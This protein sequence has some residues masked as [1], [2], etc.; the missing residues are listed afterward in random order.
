MPQIRPTKEENFLDIAREISKRSTCLRRRYGAV[1]VSKDGRIVSTGYNGAPRTRKNCCDLGVCS[2]VKLNIKPGSNYELCRAVHAEANAILNGNAA[3]IIGSTL[4]LAG[5]DSETNK[6]T[7]YIYPCSM[8]QRL[9]LNAQIEK[10]V[11]EDPD[12]MIITIS[13]KD[14]E[15]DA[16]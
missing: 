7:K 16:I 8:C 2:R 1:I 3:D 10:I 15:D 11:M 6:P 12:G 13:T 14:L 4:Y 5:I 9:I